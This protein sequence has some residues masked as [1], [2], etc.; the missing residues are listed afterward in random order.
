MTKEIINDLKETI[1]RLQTEC[2]EKTNTIIALDEQFQRLKQENEELK[3]QLE[4]YEDL[5]KIYFN[6]CKGR[7]D[8]AVVVSYIDKL[9]QAL[10]DIKEIAYFVQKSIIPFH[11]GDT[12]P[13]ADI[14][15]LEM[16]KILA[17]I[18]EV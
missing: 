16:G 2:T 17:K 10:A 5:Y 13:M 18:A 14:V 8:V 4:T 15:Q 6:L 11:V 3:A 7:K 9:K 1:N 12:H